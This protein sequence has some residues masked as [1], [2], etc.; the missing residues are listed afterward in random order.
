MGCTAAAMRGPLRCEGP[1]CTKRK[2]VADALLGYNY[3]LAAGSRSVCILY[4]R[5]CACAS[6]P[7]TR[8]TAR[9]R[10]ERGK[11]GPGGAEGAMQLAVQVRGQLRVCRRQ[12]ALNEAHHRHGRVRKELKPAAEGGLGK[13]LENP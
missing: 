9:L 3:W 2:A 4:V 5:A 10:Q 6:K 7:Q 12:H 11:Q 8:H 1:T 13:P